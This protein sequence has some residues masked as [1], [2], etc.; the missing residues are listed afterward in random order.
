MAP[1][2]IAFELTHPSQ[3]FKADDISPTSPLYSEFTAQPAMD[4]VRDMLLRR[5]PRGTADVELAVTLPA[6]QIRPG[7]EEALTVAIRRWVRVQNIIDLD[8]TEAGGAIGRR[9]LPLGILAFFL[10]QFASIL[11]KNNADP[12][13]EYLVDVVGE[14]L[15]ITSWVLLWFPVQLMTMEVWR[16]AVKRRRM[17]VLDRIS[18]RLVPAEE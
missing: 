17:R 2:V 7:L 16:S 1:F 6:D 10:F 5:Q 12:S 3:L 4:T 13:D 18:L 14:G 8:S 11:I 15:S 9:L